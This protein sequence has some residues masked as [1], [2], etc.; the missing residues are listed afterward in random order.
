MDEAVW[1][2]LGM[3]AMIAAIVW[4]GSRVKQIRLM[5]QAE[6]QNG[7]LAKFQSGRELAEFMETE[8][9]QRFL[10][11]WDIN[12]HAAIL[13]S[14]MIGI[15][16]FCLGLGFLALTVREEDLVIPGVIVL[17]LGVGF[18]IGAAVS[19]RLSDRWNADA[20]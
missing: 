14:M 15:V 4:F 19:R 1:V 9:G 6:A 5:K 17:A 13:R 12:P 7:L 20:D 10:S 18:I 8:T 11:Q 16:L 3:F 2:P